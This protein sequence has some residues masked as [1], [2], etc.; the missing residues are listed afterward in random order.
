MR[1]TYI[2][3]QQQ[4]ILRSELNRIIIPVFS[5]QFLRATEYYTSLFYHGVSRKGGQKLLDYRKSLYVLLNSVATRV[6][7]TTLLDYFSCHSILSTRVLLNLRLWADLFE[8]FYQCPTAGH[9]TNGPRKYYFFP[10]VWTLAISGKQNPILTWL[11]V[12]Q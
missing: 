9:N 11:G 8:R 7:Y 3:S 4:F 10:Y 2:A 1:Q 12:F 6:E 5:E